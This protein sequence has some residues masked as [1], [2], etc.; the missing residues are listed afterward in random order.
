MIRSF[1]NVFLSEDEYKRMRIVYFLAETTV[2]TIVILLLFGFGKYT[3]KIP[4]VNT[5]LL[6]LLGPFLMI[7]YPFLRYI[8]SGI[9]YTEIVKGIPTTFI[10]CLDLVIPTILFIPLYYLFEWV[11]LKR[12]FEKNKKL[13][14]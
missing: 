8:L 6:L 3:L 13:D 2:I 9:E 4:H 11:S 12:S 1:L 10:E 5:E 14:E 7:T